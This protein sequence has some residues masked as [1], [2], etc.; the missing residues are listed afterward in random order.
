MRTRVKKVKKLMQII[1]FHLFV[2]GLIG[3]NRKPIKPTKLSFA[4]FQFQPN[5]NQTGLAPKR[6][7]EMNL[8]NRIIITPNHEHY[9]GLVYSCE[10][11]H[12]K[13]H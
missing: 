7:T 5:Y 4:D 2:L 8:V 13:P 12:A 9:Y 10:T 11:Y 3:F 6:N 1:F